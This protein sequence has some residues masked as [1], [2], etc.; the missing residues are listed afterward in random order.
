M[1]DPGKLRRRSG[2]VNF[3][4]NMMFRMGVFHAVRQ[5]H[6]FDL[7]ILNYHRIDDLT[8]PGFDTFTPNVTAS[9]V[10]FTRQMDYLQ[11]HYNVI[12]CETL[13]AWMRWKKD[14]PPHAAMVTF[15]DGYYDNY[16]HAYPILKARNLSALIFLTTSLIGSDNPVFWDH[17]AYCFFHTRKRS[18]K[19]RLLGEVAWANGT[20]CRVV[21]K[22]WVE[23]IKILPDDEKRDA[24]DSLSSLLEV[25]VPDG[26]FSNLYLT[27]EQVREMCQNGIEIGSHTVLHPILTRIPLS[28]A[29]EELVYSKRRIESEIRKPVISFAYPNGSRSDYSPDVINLVRQTGY[30]LAF[31]LTGRASPYTKVKRH[32]FEISRI[33]LGSSDVLPRFVAKLSFGRA[34]FGY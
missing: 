31:T 17:V 33:F 28:K 2:A 30:E 6:P 29:E 3:M 25:T 34:H 32:P 12:S 21:M 1:I 13:S 24:V 9:P 11:S 5:I 15:D 22:R 8:R 20:E 4:L 14:L 19:I 26:A 27:W 18:V 10:E 23:A 16:A 7:T